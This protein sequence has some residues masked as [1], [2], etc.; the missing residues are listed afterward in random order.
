MNIKIWAALLLLVSV[1]LPLLAQDNGTI[2]GTVFDQKNGEPMI[3]TNVYIVGTTRGTTT[4]INGFFALPNVPLGTYTLETTTLGYDTMRVEFTISKNNQ[5]VPQNLYL[6][7]R[8]IKL[9]VVNISAEKEKK[10]TEVDISQVRVTTKEISQIPSVGGEPDI[11]QYLQIMPGVIF[12]GDQGGQLYI[13]GGSAVQTRVLL[14]GLLIYNPFHSIGLF[15]VFETDIVRN[16]DIS[17]GG[18][19]AE[20]GGRLSAVMDVRMQ[21]GN[22][23]RIAGKLGISPFLSKFILEGPLVKQKDN[24]SS[25]TFVLSGRYSYLDKT[26]KVLYPYVE[27]DNGIP[28][29]FGDFYGKLAF[30]GGNGSKITVFGFNFNDLANFQG[31]AKYKWN[32]FGIGTNFVLVPGGSNLLMN[33]TVGYTNYKIAL[34]EAGDQP[35]ESEVGGLNVNMNFTYFLTGGEFNYGLNV[36]AFK[37]DYS[38]FNNTG[39]IS[40]DVQNTTE[41]GLYFRFRKVIAKKLVLDPS[42]RFDYYASLANISVEPRLGLKYNFH[43]NFRFKAAGGLYSQNLISSRVDRDVVDL[44]NGFLSGPDEVLTR[45]DGS[46]ANHKLQKAWHAIA[47]FEVDLA[48]NLELNVEGYYKWF[49]QLISLNRNKLYVNE[50]NYMIEDGKAYGVDVLLKYQNKNWFL[51]GAYSLAWVTRF[52]G[53]QTYNPHYD[54]RH[55]ANFVASYTWGK[56]LTW[57][58]SLRYNVGSGFPF[59]RTQA[60]YEQVDF[61]DG[62]NTDYTSSNGSLGIIYEDDLNAGRLPAYHRLDFSIQKEIALGKNTT[63]DISASV[64][65]AYNRQNI[66]YFDRVRYTRVNQLPILPSLALSLSFWPNK[67]EA[68]LRKRVLLLLCALGLLLSPTIVQA[69]QSTVYKDPWA[70]YNEAIQFFDQQNYESA[71]RLLR[72]YNNYQI[73]AYDVPNG[74]ARSHAQ[75]LIA[76]CALELFQ[77]D[78]EKLFLD[79]I[80]STPY[81]NPDKRMAYYHLGRYHFR[82][83]NYKDALEYFQKIDTGDLSRA[84]NEEYRFMMAYAY[85]FNKDFDKA[86]PLFKQTRN[87]NNKYYYAS[88]YYYGYIAFTKG[89]V[90]EALAS[91]EKV[92]DSKTYEKIIPFYIAQIRFKKGQYK[93]VISYLQPIINDTK[94]SNF[95]ELNLTLG[96]SYYE[97][98]QY[99]N[100]IKYMEVYADKNKSLKKSEL[101]QLGYAYYQT[102]DCNN[103]INNFTQLADLKDT[104]GQNALYLLGDCYLKTGN[105]LNARSAFQKAAS[106][107]FDPVITE[108]AR[109]NYAKLSYEAG[110]DNEAVAA[111]E[112]FIKDYPKSKYGNEAK[113]LLSELLLS[114]S[115]YDKALKIIQG[116]TDQSPQVKKAYQVVAFNKGVQL[117]NNQQYD[118]AI[119]NFDLS[120]QNPIIPKFKAMAYYWKGEAFFNTG[121]YQKAGWQYSNFNGIASVSELDNAEWYIING[122]Y[123]L[124]YAF[125]KQER[126]RDATLYFEKAITDARKS[127][128]AE[129]QK[130]ILTDAILR[131]GDSY[132]MVKDYTKAISNY[133]EVYTKG[134]TGKDYAMFQKG[135]IQGLQGNYDGKVG[136]MLD[137][138]RQF[139]GS[140][141]ADDA[142][143]EAANT[144]LEQR[145]NSTAIGHYQKLLKDYPNSQYKVESYLKL[146]LVYFNEKDYKKSLENYE[147]VLQ[148][149]P[150]TSKAKEAFSGIQEIAIATGD[151]AVV[152]NIMKKYNV[153]VDEADELNY[154][155]AENQFIKKNYAQAV[156]LFNEYLIGFSKGAYA[157]NAHYY[158]ADSYLELDKFLEALPD[159]EAVVNM[160]PNHFMEPALAKASWIAFYK[161]KDYEKSYSLYKLLLENTQDKQNVFDANLGLMRSTYTLGKLNETEKYANALIATGQA[162]PKEIFEAD[163]YLGKIAFGKKNY[164]IAETQFKKIEATD[165]LEGT[166]AKY[167]LARILFINGSY[168]K[169]I[170]KAYEVINKRGGYHELVIKSYLLLADNYFKKGNN[171]QA[172][173]TV[174]S[175]IDNYA[176]EDE[177]KKEAREKLQMIINAEAG[178]N[179]LA[180]DEEDGGTLE[181]DPSGTIDLNQP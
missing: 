24:G 181:P 81:E 169:S 18:F 106:F 179:K 113:G 111:L 94:L 69:Q 2:R 115:D 9:D 134:A 1:S 151:K 14:D 64:T 146:G 36:N 131:N 82:E 16:V 33:G 172:K 165:N 54:R 164:T 49:T 57:Q 73:T 110:L 65:N 76:V 37:T 177:L 58:A 163:Y 178:T 159:Y 112:S 149:A 91:F 175:I 83:R 87:V 148:L 157:L 143:F 75:F 114:S 153:S 85:F 7:P 28:F 127:K 95:G 124:G 166:D 19:G 152:T 90:D 48:K 68:T 42:I 67:M 126:Y 43:D 30:N 150:N 92:K 128:N 45:T 117:Y 93:E 70:I 174:Q 12:T 136:T 147:R 133:D 84:E 32:S 141:Y 102:G 77:P 88:N 116:I 167:H 176:P 8:D 144:S 140:L 129:I 22:K 29:S 120:L 10:Q 41:L 104:V 56:T 78:A 47:G 62:V 118:E 158:R 156:K 100:A 71:Q 5:I 20:H 50:P 161:A 35:R 142:L 125:L 180:P 17:T 61:S 66:F 39:T 53:E 11:A 162:S 155:I 80:Y 38:F 34:Q 105:K 79:F 99:P 63:L 122:N 130:R 26:S 96:Q 3:F 13:R 103:A 123:G 89:E 138:Q 173:A 108:N 55:N 86:Y 6:T 135:L 74:T 101:Y 27:G 98:G 15:S 25:L 121:E 59:T 171:F 97:L 40:S 60:F 145:K 44:F 52:D 154:R 119:K 23:K 21:D 160:A 51:Y 31:I 46:T 137:L 72:E 168:D 139:P 109:F 170:E 107:N 132:Y 4:D